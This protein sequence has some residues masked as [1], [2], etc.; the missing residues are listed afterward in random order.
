M[1]R[2]IRSP[3][4]FAEGCGDGFLAMVDELGKN[5]LSLFRKDIGIS[6]FFASVPIYF[7]NIVRQRSPTSR[8]LD[9][10]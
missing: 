1:Q 6:C 3:H 9:N 8:D 5:I 10:E 2:E 7:W 4:V